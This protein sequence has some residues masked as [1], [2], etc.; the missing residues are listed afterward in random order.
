[1]GQASRFLVG[2]PVFRFHDS[3]SES[4]LPSVDSVRSA[5][6]AQV[7]GSDIRFFPS[8]EDAS[9]AASS[10]SLSSSLS[11]PGLR[12]RHPQPWM[13]ILTSAPGIRTLRAYLPLLPQIP[14]KPECP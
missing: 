4:S 1:M 12:Y 14:E 8:D 5:G 9:V 7:W 13:P 3:D 6:F 11:R 10:E 2:E